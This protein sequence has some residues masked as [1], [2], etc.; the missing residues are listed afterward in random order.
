MFILFFIIFNDFNNVKKSFCL[1]SLP[2]EINFNFAFSFVKNESLIFRFALK[3]I[4]FLCSIGFNITI[5][6]IFKSLF[7]LLIRDKLKSILR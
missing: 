4:V 7:N 3:L 1:V 5:D 2:I 6:F